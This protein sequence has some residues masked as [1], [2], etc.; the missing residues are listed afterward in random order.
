[1][2]TKLFLTL[3]LALAS[4]S[5]AQANIFERGIRD[6]GIGIAADA[7][8]IA[9][10]ARRDVAFAVS[11]AAAGGA[12][13]INTACTYQ[14][15]NIIEH[16]RIIGPSIVKHE[17]IKF[18]ALH[19]Q[20]GHWVAAVWAALFGGPAPLNH[21]GQQYGVGEP[22]PPSGEGPDCFNSPSPEKAREMEAQLK[23]QEEKINEMTPDQLLRNMDQYIERKAAGLSDRAVGD[24]TIRNRVRQAEIR[25]I[26]TR[27]AREI[28][29]A[30]P[31]L[32]DAEIY[33][34]AKKLAKE[35]IIGL[36]VLHTPDLGVGGNGEVSGLGDRSVNRSI[37]SQW[38]KPINGMPKGSPTRSQQ[39]RNLA[40]QAKIRGQKFMNIVL[41]VC[42]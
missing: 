13:E 12:C 20:S 14:L 36:D 7:G 37:G 22:L 4:I 35:E 24:S 8:I 5:P 10:E 27:Y 38:D 32:D 2:R 34:Q 29:K 39:I 1:M 11:A 25:H 26:A 21:T 30:Q 40:I 17:L 42:Q 33:R 3:C 15:Q 28:Q 18:A 16:H 41:N 23:A 9:I 19:P 31:D 6:S